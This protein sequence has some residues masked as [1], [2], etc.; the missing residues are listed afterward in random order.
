[1]RPVSRPTISIEAM[2][3]MPRGPMTMPAVTT[4]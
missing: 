3:P 4:G 2:V 1:M